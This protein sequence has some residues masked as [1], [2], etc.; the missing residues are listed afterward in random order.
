MTQTIRV[1]QSSIKAWRRCRKAYD[2]KYVQML[3]PRSIQRPLKFGSAVHKAIEFVANG[4]TVAAAIAEMNRERA[5]VFA[6]EVDLWDEIMRDATWVSTAYAK[7]YKKDRVKPVKLGKGKAA[8]LAEHKFEVEIARGILLT[9]LIDMIGETADERLWVVEHKTRG[10]RIENDGVR[11]RDLQTMLYT[12]PVILE[13]LGVKRVSGVLWD[14]VRSKSPPTP[15]LLKD[16]TM[17][18]RKIDTLPN[19][20][21]E[22][23]TKHGLDPADYS[24]ILGTLD[25]NQKGWFIRVN[26]PVNRRAA[27]EI[28][29]ETEY[30]AREIRRKAGVDTTRNFTRDCSWCPFEKLCTAELHGH[31]AEFIR[32][33]EYRIS[34]RHHEETTEDR[35]PD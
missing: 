32:K 18:K 24:D 16:G 12:S 3:R 19:V 26:V 34:E 1:S 2:Y 9:G 6:S 33:R 21:E 30:T 4:K 13:T 23:L 29:E 5:Q 31:D 35:D 25:E 20:Y 27:D 7:F 8:K 14:Y 10:G 15:E 17:S 22:T 11:T 28:F